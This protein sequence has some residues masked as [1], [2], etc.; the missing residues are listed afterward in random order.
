MRSLLRLLVALAL[1]AALPALAQPLPVAPPEKVGLSSERLAR[2]HKALAADVEKGALPGAVVAVARRG[3][4]AYFEAVG[5]RDPATKQVARTSA[6]RGS[7][8]A[9]RTIP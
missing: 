3:K 7:A 6:S 1:L 9:P 5:F 4:L 2:I 8:V